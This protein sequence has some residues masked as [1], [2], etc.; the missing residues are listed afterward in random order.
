MAISL[1]LTERIELNPEKNVEFSTLKVSFG[2]GY[3][4]RAPNGINYRREKYTINWVGLCE[5]DM[6]T[7]T[8]ALDVAGGHGEFLW[9]PYDLGEKKFY[10]ESGNYKVTKRGDR[11][12]VSV[13]L[14]QCFS[15]T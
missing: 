9:N 14:K 4:Q 1:P 10:N 6:I 7:I 8:D 11:Y 13:E 5:E 12:F 15:V 2:N 3:E